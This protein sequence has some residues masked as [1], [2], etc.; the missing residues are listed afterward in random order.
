LIE[1]DDLPDLDEEGKTLK[2]KQESQKKEKKIQ[3][4]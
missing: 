4:D 3:W 1:E 2:Q